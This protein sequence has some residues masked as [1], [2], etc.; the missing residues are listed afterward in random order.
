M[1]KKVPVLLNIFF[2]F[3]LLLS[4]CKKNNIDI[5]S[6]DNVDEIKVTVTNTMGDV[7]M[8][9]VT[10]KKEIERLSIKIHMVFGETKKHLGLLL[11]N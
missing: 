10:D 6:P 7:K 2:L 11:K 5:V 8:F 9:T 3:F 1:I 4:S